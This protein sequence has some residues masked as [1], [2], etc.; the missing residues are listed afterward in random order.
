MKAPGV[1]PME[2]GMRVSDLLLAGGRLSEEAY[3]LR[4]ELARYQ[5]VNGEYRTSEV[6]DIDLDAFVSFRA[7]TFQ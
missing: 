5:V 2:P 4:A 1:Y 3:T 6:I 7:V